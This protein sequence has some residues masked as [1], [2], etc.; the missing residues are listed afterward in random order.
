[1][2][3]PPIALSRRTFLRAAAAAGVTACK[4]IDE[5]VVP[6]T[7]ENIVLVMMENRSFDHVF[8]ARSLVEGLPGDGLVA[9]LSNPDPDGTP[10]A[11]FVVEQFCPPD[12]PHG[13]DASRVA[14]ADGTNTGF[15]QACF[16]KYD[17]VES[18][19]Q[20]MGYQLREHQPVSWALADG[21]CLCDR[22]FS[23]VCG[24]TWPNRMYFHGAQS[25]GMTSN[26]LPDGG[27]YTMPAIWDRLD[28]AG[29]AWAY[30]YSSLPYISLFQRF[31]RRDELQ[32]LDA[33]FEAARTGTLPPV[34][35]IEPAFGV[36]DD[37]PP[38]HPSLGQVFLASVYEALAQSPQWEKMLIVFTYDEAGGF[39]D[40]VPPGK[41]ADDRA[42]DGF[43][44]L[45]FRVPAIVAGPWVRPG[46]S[47]V[48]LDHTS[49]IAHVERMFGLDPL[50]AR[51]AAANDLSSMI[52]ADRLA[53]NDPLPPAIV[54]TVAVTEAELDATC[55]RAATADTGQRELE[56]VVPP[57]LDLRPEL[58]DT[59]LRLVDHAVRLG[60]CELVSA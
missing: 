52:D 24:P 41:A 16:D 46:I 59:L 13:W 6:G 53:A 56:A 21:Y 31:N 19:R 28:E 40:H 54:P 2:R 45:G 7:I 17:D 27:F 12:P 32:R 4:K 44:Q 47:S 55:R 26:D 5:P 49:A 37:H 34:C 35:M 60:V 36:N 58:G 33:F 48:E 50:T 42:A 9:G 43:D 25:Q 8:G 38:A 1:V 39:F 57:H 20:V 23:S 51:D 18:A 15:V 10:I 11:P 14:L 3:R 30:Y 22:W 29:V